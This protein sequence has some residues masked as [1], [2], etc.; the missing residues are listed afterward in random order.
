M[1]TSWRI[2]SDQG[3][4]AWARDGGFAHRLSV[5]PLGDLLISSRD[6]TYGIV[7]PG[8]STPSGVPIVRVRDLHGGRVK[9]DDPLEV[10]P[11]VAASYSRSRL[12]GGELLVTLVGTVGETAVAGHNLA[13]WNVARAVAVARVRP[14]IGARWITWVMKLSDSTNFIAE[15]VN[16]TVQ[17][18]LN[19]ADL[20]ELRVPLPPVAERDGIAAVLGALDNKIDSNRRLVAR[21]AS[22]V[23]ALVEQLVVEHETRPVALREVV[24]FNRES[25]RPGAPDFGVSYIDIASVSPGSV[26][27]AVQTTWAD[28]PSRARRGVTDGDV[29]FSTVRPGR[30]SHAQILDPDP[31]TVVST[32]FAVMT[33]SIR[34]GSSQL[35]SVVGSLQFSEYLE[36]VAHGSAYPAVSIGA[37][38][39]YQF[40][41][42]ADV[43]VISRFEEAT[44]PL[45]RRAH[46]ASRE[47]E[48][49]GSLLDAL[50]PELLSG[51][52]R[53][54][55]AFEAVA[56]TV[57]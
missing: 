1:L 3:S 23:D 26:D 11:A 20:R 13:G 33:P 51:R 44:M 49:L 24:E 6:L 45:R 43:A 47:T 22:L 48:V 12:S 56:R 21:V 18:T 8:P 42:P 25:R 10:A 29:I 16:T 41:L 54:P 2:R 35:T 9:T 32:G 28:A 40:E 55:E 57:T 30:R 19:L 31:R 4:G 39:D 38:G 15:R 52:V 14:E 34:L 46:Q 5:A 17:T 37:M 7:Q 36:S 27:S 53:V 50:L